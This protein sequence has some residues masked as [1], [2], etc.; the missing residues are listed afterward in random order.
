MHEV[1]HSFDGGECVRIKKFIHF[2]VFSRSLCN[3]KYVCICE[4]FKTSFLSFYRV[5]CSENACTTF[6]ENGDLYIFIF[7]AINFC[8]LLQKFL[9]STQSYSFR[10]LWVLPGA[11]YSAQTYTLNQLLTHTLPTPEP[12]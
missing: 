3:D 7:E 4:V 6:H 9:L 2:S 1:M 5:E 8:K 12:S 10:L 11:A